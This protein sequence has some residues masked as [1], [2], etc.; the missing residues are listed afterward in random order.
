VGF[1]GVPPQQPPP[2]PALTTA[3]PEGPFIRTLQFGY[4]YDI[5]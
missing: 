4:S 1:G 3:I 5:I 2:H